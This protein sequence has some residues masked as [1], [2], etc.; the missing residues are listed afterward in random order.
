MGE[1]EILPELD[2]NSHDLQTPDL[3]P[4]LPEQRISLSSAVFEG[5]KKSRAWENDDE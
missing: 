2:S 3:Q 1:K 4:Y 5:I